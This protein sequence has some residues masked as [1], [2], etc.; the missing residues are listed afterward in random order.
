MLSCNQLH[1]L[2]KPFYNIFY[3]PFC[4]TQYRN[5]FAFYMILIFLFSFFLCICFQV[6]H[7]CFYRFAWY[8]FLKI[9]KNSIF[10]SVSVKLMCFTLTIHHKL[11]SRKGS[12]QFGFHSNRNIN[13]PLSKWFSLIKFTR[14]KC[15]GK[16][17]VNKLTF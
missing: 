5:L 13:I 11:R 9:N 6:F 15:C 4:I 16:K 8:V 7:N 3:S 2:N 10:V 14:Y 1:L 17:E 12:V